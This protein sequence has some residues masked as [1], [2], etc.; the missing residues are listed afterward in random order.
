MDCLN[1]RALLLGFGAAGLLSGAAPFWDRK[2]PSEWSGDEIIQL[3]TRSPWARETNLDLEAS[4]GGHIELPPGGGSAGQDGQLSS[5]RGTP[6]DVTPGVLRRTPVLVRWESAQPLRDTLQLPSIREFEGRYVIGVSNIPAAVMKRK[7][8][9][10]AET[11]ALSDFLAELQGAASLEASGK[12]PVGAGMVRHVPGSANN[13]LFGFS[14][15]LL[16]LTGREKEVQFVLR[17][18]LV[19]VRAKFEPKNMLYRGQPAL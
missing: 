11:I 14:K 12:E 13:Y 4:T 6:S 17:T 15:E 18:S 3:L 8:R 7:F 16:A 5:G 19:S 1:R 10:D 2:R 9:A